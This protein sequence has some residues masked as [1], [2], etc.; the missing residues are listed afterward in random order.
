MKLVLDTSAYSAFNRG[1][2]RLKDFFRADNEILIP[3]IVVG[4]L[5]AGFTLGGRSQENELLLQRLLDSPQVSVVTITD[6]TTRLF[7]ALFQRLRAAGTPI[8]TNDMWIASLVL[9]H[10][11]SLV[12]LDTDFARV[13]DLLIARL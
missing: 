11:C 5:R 8:G 4:E 10:D 12:T 6:Q 7:A 1:D 9:E 3:L 2:T 13:P